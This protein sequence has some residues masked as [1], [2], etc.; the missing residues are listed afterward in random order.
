MISRLFWSSN[1]RF[2][3]ATALRHAQAY[4]ATILKWTYENPEVIKATDMFQDTFN[5]TWVT[6]F[7]DLS[8][9]EKRHGM[10]VEESKELLEVGKRVA[11]EA[12]DS[13][14]AL[15]GVYSYAILSCCG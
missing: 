6:G 9:F 13:V 1:T 14:A 8:V 12:A 10:D 15:A 4:H 7:D 5:V 2:L 3:R 11:P